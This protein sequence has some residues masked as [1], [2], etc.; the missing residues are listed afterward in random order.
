MTTLRYPV[1]KSPFAEGE[2]VVLITGE[3]GTAYRDG[4]GNMAYL[5]DDGV[6]YLYFLPARAK[7][8][9]RVKTL[10]ITDF[11]I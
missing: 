7:D 10:P 8:L 2:P 4:W 6:I 11:V 5:H 9:D 1:A 3:T